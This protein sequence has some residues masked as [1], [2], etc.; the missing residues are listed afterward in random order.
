MRRQVTPSEARRVATLELD[1][2]GFMNE[3]RRVLS[4]RSLLAP[5]S[6]TSV[7]DNDRARRDRGG[8]GQVDQRQAGK[9]L[10]QTDAQRHA[11]SRIERP[12]TPGATVE[13]TIDEHLQYIVERELRAG[14]AANRADGGTAIVM[15]PH[16][17]EILAHGELCRRS[18]RTPT[19]ESLRD[20]RRNRAIQDIYEP[21]STFKIVTASAAIEEQLVHP[22]D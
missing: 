3:S 16:T 8:L 22:T 7:L 2:I 12:P 21:G 18:T 20:A 1:G 14:V 11:F 17:G 4:E 9:V 6:A 19:R 15:D 5:R 10:V 13:L